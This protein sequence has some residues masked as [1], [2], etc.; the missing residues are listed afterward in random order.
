MH[1]KEEIFRKIFIL[2]LLENYNSTL[3]IDNRSMEQDIT[4]YKQTQ[5]RHS[6]ISSQNIFISFHKSGRHV[7]LE[8]FRVCFSHS[9]SIDTRIYPIMSVSHYRPQN[10]VTRRNIFYCSPINVDLPDLCKYS[11]F[12]EKKVFLISAV[13]FCVS[14]ELMYYY[15]IF[16]KKNLKASNIVSISLITE[17]Y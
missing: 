5:Q 11:K 4:V 14:S 2:A 9:R 1:K 15:L 13:L 10:Y 3:K 7:G 16:N 6:Y 12:H 17:A 8:Y